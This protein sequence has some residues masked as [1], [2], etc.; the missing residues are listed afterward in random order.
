MRT[1]KNNW[2]VGETVDLPRMERLLVKDRNALFGQ[3]VDS[4][5]VCIREESSTQCGILLRVLGKAAVEHIKIKGGV[6][7]CK[8][9]Y[10]EQFYVTHYFSHPFPSRG[11]VNQVLDILHDNPQLML[12]LGDA[13]KTVTLDSTF[14]V[15]N[16]SRNFLLKKQLQFLDAHTRELHAASSNQL[17]YRLSIVYFYKGELVW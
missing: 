8:D 12:Q 5:Y 6:P 4:Q 10:D 16:I 7:F 11:K 1:N 17:C 13:S 2:T 3:Y 9:N 15:E 14:W